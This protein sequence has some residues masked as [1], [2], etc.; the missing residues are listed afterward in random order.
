MLVY[1]GSFGGVRELRT[2][3]QSVLGGVGAISDDQTCIFRQRSSINIQLSF[4]V[5][6]IVREVVDLRTG[7]E[8][9]PVRLHCNRAVSISG[10]K[11]GIV[12]SEMGS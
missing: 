5:L 9:G 1:I 2:G 11:E 3:H 10:F 12:D 7:G 4:R 8:E 6:S